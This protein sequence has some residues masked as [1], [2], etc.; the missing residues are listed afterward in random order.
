MTFR[1]WFCPYCKTTIRLW[2]GMVGLCHKEECK[3]AQNELV[4]GILTPV[5]RIVV[6]RGC[7]APKISITMDV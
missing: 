1:D 3:Q 7:V 4:D 5:Q 6:V 2:L